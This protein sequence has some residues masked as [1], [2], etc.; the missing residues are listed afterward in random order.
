[1]FRK[2]G[3]TRGKTD[4]VKDEL[5]NKMLEWNSKSLGK[6]LVFYTRVTFSQYDSL[7]HQK[8]LLWIPVNKVTAYF[9]PCVYGISIFL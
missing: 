2:T 1:M 6:T 9:L 4:L 7:I 8:R 3:K 5:L